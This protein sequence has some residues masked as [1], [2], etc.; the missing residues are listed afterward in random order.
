MKL[1]RLTIQADTANDNF[2][3]DVDFK[4]EDIIGIETGH[5]EYSD[6]ITIWFLN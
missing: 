2:F 3:E 5:G 4:K 6:W 1:K